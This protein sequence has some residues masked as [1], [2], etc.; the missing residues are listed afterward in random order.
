MPVTTL[1]VSQVIGKTLIADGDVDYFSTINPIG[2]KIGTFKKG[3]IIGIIY[4]YGYGN[5]PN[6]YWMINRSGNYIFVKHDI[7]K[8][9]IAGGQQ[10]LQDIQNQQQQAEIEQKG[11]LRYYLDKY[12]PLIIG[13]VAVS[14]VLPSVIKLVKNEKN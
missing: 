5:T 10:I 9:Q 4:S 8:L 3:D 12:L 11:L 1:N 2:A 14:F 13:A 7:N 6:L